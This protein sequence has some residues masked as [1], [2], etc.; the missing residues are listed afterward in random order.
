MV[1]MPSAPP[2]PERPAAR[3]GR[4]PASDTSV[5]DQAPASYEQALAELEQ[6]V[7]TMEAGQMPLE[8]LLE[9]YRRGATLLAYCRGRLD[10]VESQVRLLEDGTLKPW[11]ESP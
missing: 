8:R 2:S 7:Q 6:I 10:A 3:A 5:V 1:A 11:T 9:G 4:R